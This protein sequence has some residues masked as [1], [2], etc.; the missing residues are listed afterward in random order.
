LNLDDHDRD[1]FDA[2]MEAAPAPGEF[3]VDPERAA[4]VPVMAADDGRVQQ[5]RAALGADA[6]WDVDA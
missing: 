6:E 2:L 5:R 4:Q 3:P 1:A